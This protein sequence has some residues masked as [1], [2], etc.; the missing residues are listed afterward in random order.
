M[1]LH[2]GGARRWE[3]FGKIERWKI[4]SCFNCKRAKRKGEQKKQA[5]S[6][7]ALLNVPNSIIFSNCSTRSDWT[8][9]R[10]LESLTC[11]SKYVSY[12]IA[13][14]FHEKENE[15]QEKKFEV[16]GERT[17]GTAATAKEQDSPFP[18]RSQRNSRITQRPSLTFQVCRYRFASS[19][20]T[21]VAWKQI[22]RM[23][24]V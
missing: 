7:T 21:Y 22:K 6:P 3:R 11:K 18:Q 14:K 23:R 10:K 24:A 8:V 17:N 20:V 9:I 4:N 16:Q 2:E 12:R 5:N 1:T 19:P 15:H 13:M